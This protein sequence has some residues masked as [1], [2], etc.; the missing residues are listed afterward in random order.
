MARAV[1][2]D[3]GT[4][5]SVVSVLEGGE[6]TVITNTEGARTTPSVVG[7]AKGGDVLVGEI[8]KRQAV[9]NVERTARSVKRHMGDAQW[10]FPGTGSIDG[11]R[12]TAQ[13]I[14]ARVL[15]KLKR[16][17]EA[18]L[19]EDVTDAVITVPAY[20][21][22]AQRTA[23]KEAGEIAGL[24]VLRIINEPTAAALAYGLDKEND[25]TILV[26]DLGGG[27]FDVSLLEIGEGVVE[28]KAT[29]G[30]THLG[31][32][33]WDQ[34]IVEYLAKQFKNNYGVDLF[35]DKMAVQRLR[36]AAE[37]AKIEL[38]A[39]TE[40][41]VNLPYI[42]ASAEGPLHLDE[43]LTRAQF[44]QLTADLLERCKTPFH[45]AV[46]DAGIKLS[47]INHV[48]L[49]G[50]STRMP[51]VTELVRE[52][53]GKDPH[54]GVNPDEV[55]AVG[56][57]LQAGVLKGEVKDVLLLDVTPLSLGI[58]TKGGIMTKLI[59]RNTT[60]PTKRSEIFTTAEDNQPS[61]QIQVFQGER[62][63]A[64]YNKKLGMFELTGLPPAPRG[65]PQIE[66]AFDIDANG[67]M[68]VS[69]KDLG[70]GREQ[71]MTVTGGSALPKDDIDR[72]VREAEQHAEEDRRRREAA[73]TRNQ[74]EQLVYQTERLIR[75]NP[76]KIPDDVKAETETALAEL[77][78]KLK[79]ESAEGDNT[80]AIRTATE[81][82]A[83]AAQKIG[84]AM[85]AQAQAAQGQA[86]E[87]QGGAR[88]TGATGTEEDVV[89]AE[90]VDD[91]QHSKGGTG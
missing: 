82:A 17:A 56:A 37:K 49:V 12:Y 31:G 83:A 44:Q 43:K 6:P 61:V 35:K 26:F 53:T 14:S 72:M 19:G 55:V 2:I 28:V 45:N 80:A 88:S 91:E 60:I 21:N 67:I 22:D 42:S 69:A 48:I 10:R 59:E 47:D 70:T 58:E 86:S 66:V 85:Y 36:E 9:T 29:N 3:L 71:K 11:K 74:A 65:I 34:R 76:G 27:T 64:A 4:T 18:Y 39:A 79:G 13:E 16:D 81:K 62:E 50:G 84:S 8:A 87:A 78:E 24:K 90:I 52:L 68:H 25:Q 33:D 75:D 73:E 41:T 5:N 77:K 38:S 1:G 89:D 57:A 20:F 30:D 7:F 54:K 15:Q 32:D 63:I 46:K 40:T 51:A 23:T